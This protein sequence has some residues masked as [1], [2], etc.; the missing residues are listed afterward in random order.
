MN[1]KKIIAIISVLFMFTIFA[2]F[3]AGG[4]SVFW[5][6]PYGYVIENTNK[7]EIEKVLSDFWLQLKNKYGLIEQRV[8]DSF[9]YIVWSK[10]ERRFFI[11]SVYT[12][13][14]SPQVKI[15]LDAS[16]R[17]SIWR[18]RNYN[19]FFIDYVFVYWDFPENYLEQRKTFEIEFDNFINS[20]N[21]SIKKVSTKSQE[22]RK[23]W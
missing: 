17:S 5:S 19:K 9:E 16:S 10:G 3:G 15:E 11:E 8:G 13:A 23:R 14:D 6:S 7:E 18:R 4:D 2:I 1:G 22:W 21:L 12:T 20:S